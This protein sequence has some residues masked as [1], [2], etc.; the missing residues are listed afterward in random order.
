MDWELIE[1]AGRISR[2]RHGQEVGFFLPGMFVYDGRRGRFPAISLTGAEC[3]LGCLH[4]RGRLLETMSPAQDP[5]VLLKS[6]RQVAKSGGRG[7]LISGG[8][9][10]EGRLPWTRFADALARIKAE[11]GLHV[12]VHAGFPDGRQADLLKRAGVDSVMLDVIGDDETQAAV[13]GLN[14]A[15]RAAESLTALTEAGLTVIP[16]VVV[17][18]HFG[19][20]RG[21][22][23]AVE[24]ISRARVGRVVFV[25]FMPLAGTP[26]AGLSPPPVE[27][28]VGLMVQTR[29]A[30]PELVQHL[31]CAKPRGGYRRRLDL[32]ALRAGVNHLAIPAPQAVEAA[33]SLG[34]E[35]F[36]S[37]TCCA[38]GQAGR[39]QE[40]SKGESASCPVQMR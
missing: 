18:L 33:P 21:E 38:L 31:G 14:G 19:Q 8:C 13:Y 39:D 32:L 40:K 5:A 7:L 9:D 36:W 35:P 17:G 28:V 1:Q 3:R 11:T 34:L 25:V 10:L 27:E 15:N 20:L 24:M 6:A 29:L 22:E 16:H 23:R 26:M 12:A 4:C 30:H 2:Q 37:E